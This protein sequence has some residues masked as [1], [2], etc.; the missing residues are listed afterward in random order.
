M[1]EMT[2]TRFKKMKSDLITLKSDLDVAIQ[3][4]SEAREKGDLRENEEYQTA[5]TRVKELLKKK[6]ELESGISE[7]VIVGTDNSPR[8][9]IGSTV[10]VCRVDN[11]NKPI[12]EAREFVIDAKGD[13]IIKHVLGVESPL[14][15]A[16]LNGTDGIYRVANNGGM[17]Y[18]VKKL[19]KDN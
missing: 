5:T 14:G 3:E 1:A 8:I 17:S 19:K 18:L 7:A 16:V 2:E 9:T 12:E 4:R 11:N 10:S 15:K 13:T 6:Q